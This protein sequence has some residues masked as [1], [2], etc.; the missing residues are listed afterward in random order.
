M[1]DVDDA[2]LV[3]Y[4]Q[5]LSTA[6][7]N[8][9][10][11]QVISINENEIDNFFIFDIDLETR[12][13]FSSNTLQIILPIQYHE[14]YQFEIGNDFYLDLSPIY[15]NVP[16]KIAGF[17]QKDIDE[18]AF[19]N[20]YQDSTYQ[21]INNNAILITSNNKE[22]LKEELIDRY[23][24]QMM[25]IYDYRAE[26]MLPIENQLLKVKTYIT[27][28]IEMMI[29]SFVISL[30]NHTTMLHISKSSD[31][32]KI[33]TLGLSKN[34][35]IYYQILNQMIIFL[36]TIGVSLIS[37]IMIYKA[38]SEFISIFGTYEYLELFIPSIYK[39]FGI[40]LCIWILIISYQIVLI[41]KTN[42]IALIRTY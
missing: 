5:N 3:G 17:Y 16:F 14:I 26:V 12:E 13:R 41:K 33:Y 2:V 36:V 18:L 21:D 20:L 37:F 11:E 32:A 27:F 35:I 42:Y 7:E 15:Q 22:V 9:A 10:L 19:I 6:F 25:V 4:Y 39:T 34:K 38:L 28:V 23:G 29:L 1:E 8:K 40:N 24:Q 30:I 31:D